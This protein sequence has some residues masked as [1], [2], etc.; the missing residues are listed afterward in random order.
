MHG[1]EESAEEQRSKSIHTEALGRIIISVLTAF[2]MPLAGEFKYK[3]HLPSI[4]FRQLFTGLR[5]KGDSVIL[6]SRSA[7][8]LLKVP[9]DNFLF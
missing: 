9:P 8:Q 2:S 7:N 1:A 6:Y 3:S 4:H 5:I